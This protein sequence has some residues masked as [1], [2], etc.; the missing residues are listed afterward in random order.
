L[1]RRIQPSLRGKPAD[2]RA[3]NDGVAKRARKLVLSI[4]GV[5]NEQDFVLRAQGQREA[6]RIFSIV[7]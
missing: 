3:F 6:G 1:E 7:E 2:E 4:G 5:K